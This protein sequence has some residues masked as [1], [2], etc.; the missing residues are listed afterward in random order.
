MVADRVGEWA[1]QRRHR[2]WFWESGAPNSS[3][4]CPPRTR[5]PVRTKHS[6][7]ESQVATTATTATTGSCKKYIWGSTWEDTGS[8]LREC[9]DL[10][11]RRVGTKHC[12][13]GLKWQVSIIA[14]WE[15]IWATTWEDTGSVHH[16]EPKDRTH[17]TQNIPNSNLG[18]RRRAYW[19]LLLPMF[20]FVSLASWLLNSCPQTHAETK[21]SP[22]KGMI[23]SKHF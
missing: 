11:T 14:A 15:N 1:T 7:L 22:Y 4:C 13:P 10:K 23:L 12:V 2:K 3:C 21:H 8:G 17:T 6:R 19:Q 16:T 20:R 9:S 18:N 5:R